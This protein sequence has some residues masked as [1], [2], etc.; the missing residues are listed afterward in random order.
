MTQAPTAT[1]ER[2][3]FPLSYAQQ[4]L[5]FLD[6][7]EP[8]SAAYNLPLVVRVSG[9][10]QRAALEQALSQ[11]VARHETLRTTYFE[12][13][14][15]PQQAVE[16]A[17]PVETIF[18][19][20]SGEVDAEAAGRELTL[21]EVN[22]PFALDA[23]LPLRA[24]LVRL[25]EDEHLFI[26]VLHHIAAD[27]WSLG[28]LFAELGE[29]YRA[30]LEG[31]EPELSEL[32]VQYADYTMW[33]REL[34]QGEY[35]EQQLSFWREQLAGAPSVLDLP[36]DRPRPAMQSDN[37]AHEIAHLDAALTEQL[38]ALGQQESA[39]LFMT[40][41]AG[42][43]AVLSRITGQSDI[44]VGTPIANRSRVELEGLI[45]FFANT[46]ALRTETNGE[47]TFRE[48]VR[49]VR[50]VTLDAYAHQDLPFERLVSELNPQRELSH[51]P[52]FQVLFALQN[53][54]GRRL[55]LPGLTLS[56][57]EIE[58]G[59]SK[60]DLA[61]FMSER[62]DGMRVSIEY[63][64]DLFD[65]ATARRML[66][67]IETFLRA[68]AADA[69]ASIAEL[70]I[71][72]T[73]ERD[74]LTA[75]NATA[76]DMEIVPVT[77]LV[78]RQV[79]AT[80]DAV[81]VEGGSRT[82]S[83]AE[84]NARANQLA[85]R[86][87]EL[88]V[89]ADVPVALCLERSPE[90]AVAVLATLKAGG[91][92]APIDPAY[93]AKR[94][95]LMLEDL[96]T[97]VLVAHAHLAERLP[98]T[99][100]EL[101]V[102]D[103]EWAELADLPDQDLEHRPALSDLA[104]VLFTSGSTGRPKGVAMPHGPLANL[105]AWQLRNWRT[106]P[107]GARTLQFASISFDVAFQELFS[108]W[109]S[110][111]RLVLVEEETRRDAQAL[112]QLLEARSVERLFLPFVAVHHLA[113][114]SAHLGVVPHALREVLTA[115]EALQATPAIRDLFARTG[116]V[117]EN[118]YGPTE[119]HVIT[120][121]TV[122]GPPDTWPDRPPIGKPIAN[123]Q[124][125]L[126]DGHNRPVPVGVPGELYLGGATLAREYLNQPERTA[127]RFLPDP[128]SGR[129]GARLY[130]TGD[131]GKLKPDGTL[132]YLGRID[133]QQVKI[134][135]YRVE[136]GEIEAC[137]LRHP[138]VRE[139][140]T[141]VRTDAA[142]QAQLVAYTS[143]LG[144]T[145][146]E[147]HAFVQET[148]PEFMVPTAFVALERL[149]LSPNGKVDR[150]ALPEPERT[151]LRPSEHV[152]PR[153]E[154]ERT[155]AA[156]WQRLL[157]LSEEVGV[158]DDFFALG[159]HSLLAVKVF[160]EIE[161]VFRIRLP[162]ATLFQTA[163]VE[164]VA[165]ALREERYR[166]GAWDTIVPMRDTG[167]RPPLYVLPGIDG[168]AFFYHDLV[169]YLSREQ[170]VYA[171]QAAGLDGR[172]RPHT[173]FEEMAAHYRAELKRFQPEGPYLLAGHCLAGVVAYELG[174]QLVEGGDDVAFLALIDASP[175]GHRRPG[176]IELERS[177]LSDFRRR[178]VRGKSA[179]I[180][181]RTRG[182]WIKATKR[183]SWFLFDL[184]VRARLLPPPVLRDVRAAG[185]RAMRTY[186]T[187]PSPCHVTLFRAAEPGRSFYGKSFW[188]RLAEGG[189]EIRPVRGEGIHHDNI[190]KEPYARALAA[191]LEAALNGTEAHS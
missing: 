129:D 183:S 88:G 58:R 99:G 108:T 152:A 81:A 40:L 5:W 127:E 114:A 50:A 28:V 79:R 97:P 22:R 136:L 138:A 73:A 150:L 25:R 178:G 61:I 67:W 43:Q 186:K 35:L 158:T 137:L 17:G 131:L 190:M 41:L 52:V 39:S 102:L 146:E 93:P 189:V 77:D 36:T 115:G 11:L 180:A 30:A 170:P 20:L 125:W 179:W 13:D 96:S 12:Q 47:P 46:L 111:G 60:W 15:E 70:P 173:T 64:T 172:T 117:L 19:D 34:L 148:L 75:W 169:R 62:P 168:Q 37:G 78:E 66:G 101:V 143:P 110:G 44:V 141:V 23:D 27:G 126:L 54:P 91:A 92:Y 4:R 174:R 133:H 120:A 182:L 87:Q 63:N 68:A 156:I 165:N 142:G 103:P 10:L 55:D 48:L 106:E 162:L 33:Q 49:R 32:P 132:E 59:R 7:F 94:I 139:A 149:P 3:V 176:R 51:S 83:Y 42:V 29:L 147:L 166:R 145:A 71:L 86:L 74:E 112:L 118:Q 107:A 175:F 18:V 116:A 105:I 151:A 14:G 69:D 56:T 159:G 153:D 184:F 76:A 9:K 119:S 140:A 104:Y 154:F 57:V 82:L 134:R 124:V 160:A 24:T 191:E 171:F 157:G 6:R 90:L 98:A 188:S 53:T 113:E 21:A 45:G 109:A 122:E 181:R 85:R 185:D 121:H 123:A 130:R 72:T 31:R 135:G 65:A 100:A 95:E 38:K 167:S 1:G 163:T 161:Q 187:P 144:P 177:K 2:F 155:V 16:P 80:P 84:L 128:F 89:G 26:V 164:H 8:G